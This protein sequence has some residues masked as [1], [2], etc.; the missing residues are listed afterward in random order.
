MHFV[1]MNRKRR[2]GLAGVLACLALNIGLFGA[3]MSASERR[4]LNDALW[5]WGHPAGVYNESYLVS[6]GRRSTIEP[7]D[8]ARSMGI[9]NIIFVCYQGKPRPPFDEYYDPFRK[10]RH[11]YWSLVAA[12][13]ATSTVSREAAF[14]LAG[15]QENLVGWILDDFFHEPS[16]GNAGD[17]IP[18]SSDSKPFHASLTPEEL[19]L[20]G[21]RTVRGRH[22]PLMAV[23][24][25]GQL[26]PGAK[27]HIAEI[28]QLCLWTSRPADLKNLEA[29]FVA[30]E[31]LAPGKDLF[32]GCYMYDFHGR[33]PL[34]VELMR[35]QVE[36]GHRWLKEGRIA[37][38]IF[39]ATAN[40]DV[41]LEAVDWT[42]RWIREHGSEPIPASGR[43]L[44][45]NS[46]GG[47]KTA[48]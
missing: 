27:A 6:T 39:L 32:L 40:V 9:S 45:Q 5:I 34:P 42:R 1:G 7:V 28:D 44:K 2:F 41:G 11:V 26:K 48:D 20:L 4:P 37:G 47:V 16:E 19:R 18:G 15:K 38:I 43:P 46:G 14:A 13:G 29:N 36:Q 12:E 24:Y 3:S 21:K 10:M 23:V 30:L 35:L 33:K 22:L 17:L 31:K 25:T 8:A